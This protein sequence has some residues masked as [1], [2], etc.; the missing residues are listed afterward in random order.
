MK[1]KQPLDGKI[2]NSVSGKDEKISLAIYHMVQF[3]I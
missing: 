3:E 1:S 2:A